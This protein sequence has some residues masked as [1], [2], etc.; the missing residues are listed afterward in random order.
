MNHHFRA[1]LTIREIHLCQAKR[2]MIQLVICPLKII[3]ISI[4]ANYTVLLVSTE[5]RQGVG[6]ILCPAIRFP[7]LYLPFL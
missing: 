4:S 5:A 2:F 6:S 7:I 1:G 3:H